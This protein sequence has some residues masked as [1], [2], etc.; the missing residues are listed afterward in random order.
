MLLVAV[1][2]GGVL[3]ASV[4]GGSMIWILIGCQGFGHS[5]GSGIDWASSR[6]VSHL[7]KAG[8]TMVATRAGTATVWRA[9]SL[10]RILIGLRR[11]GNIGLVT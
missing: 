9:K 7:A 4:L 11:S 6:K 10:P 1:T 8:H 2:V 3:V 5:R